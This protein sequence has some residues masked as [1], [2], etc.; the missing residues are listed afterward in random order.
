MI[1]I[2]HD[3]V[4]CYCFQTILIFILLF[5]NMLNHFLGMCLISWICLVARS[6]SVFLLVRKLILFQPTAMTVRLG[7]TFV[8]LFLFFPFV[9]FHIDFFVFCYINCILFDF[10]FSRS[11]K[12]KNLLLNGTVAFK[13]CQ[14]T[15]VS[16]C[17]SNYPVWLPYTQRGT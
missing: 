14:I 10:F 9:C 7:F 3:W 16:L 11:L 4:F 12:E 8:I 5:L 6:E 2:H 13:V 15:I 17:F 1:W